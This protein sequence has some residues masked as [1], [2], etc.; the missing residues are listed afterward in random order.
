ML[1]S[2]F[3]LHI[4]I[5]YSCYMFTSD[6]HIRDSNQIL[7]SD[8]KTRFWGSCCHTQ[9]PEWQGAK[10]DAESC[11]SPVESHD[12]RRCALQPGLACADSADAGVHLLPLGLEPTHACTV[13]LHLWED[14][15]THLTQNVVM[16]GIPHV[17]VVAVDVNAKATGQKHMVESNLG[18]KEVSGLYS[19]CIDFVKTWP[20]VM[21]THTYVH[22]C[23]VYTFLHVQNT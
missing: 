6:V 10:G 4:H 15:W 2:I 5:R 22:V 19:A 16:W 3:I 18:P 11:P 1:I 9:V 23:A 13:R 20:L 8:V 7:I 21:C 14:M 12:W 17:H